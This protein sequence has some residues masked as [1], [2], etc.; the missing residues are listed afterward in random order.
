MQNQTQTSNA[1]VHICMFFI[2]LPLNSPDLEKTF[3]HPFLL[4]HNVQP[5]RN[6]QSF[7]IYDGLLSF[8]A[9]KL[10]NFLLD[11]YLSH[12]LCLMCCFLAPAAIACIVSSEWEKTT[13]YL[14]LNCTQSKAK[15]FW[16]KWLC[17]YELIWSSLMPSAF[18][19]C[20]SPLSP[21]LSP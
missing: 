13:Q 6:Q 2:S 19:I 5:F 11:V 21:L 4:S 7:C 10:S 20:F 8:F 12:L 17:F 15:S 18:L 9:W 1:K 3:P 16:D 14:C